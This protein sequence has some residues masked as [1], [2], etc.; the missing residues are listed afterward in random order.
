MQG[1]ERNVK[2]LRTHP[3]SQKAFSFTLV[4]CLRLPHGLRLAGLTPAPTRSSL[5]GVRLHEWDDVG[6]GSQGAWRQ[7]PLPG[8]LDFRDV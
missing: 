7:V 5:P 6:H 3:L 1:T 4:E 2:A 8:H